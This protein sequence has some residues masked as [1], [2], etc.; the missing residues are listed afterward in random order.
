MK[1]GSYKGVRE[2]KLLESIRKITDKIKLWNTCP[3]SDLIDDDSELIIGVLSHELEVLIG[4]VRYNV[5]YLGNYNI[6]ITSSDSFKFEGWFWKGMGTIYSR[7]SP[8]AVVK[9]RIRFS[10]F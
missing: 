10:L 4:D 7:S 5:E 3:A 9:W 1:F 2:V 6:H 8:S